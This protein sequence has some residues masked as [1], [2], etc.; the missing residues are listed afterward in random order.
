[1]P[2]RQP[3]MKVRNSPLCRNPI[4]LRLCTLQSHAG[5][6]PSNHAEHPK[7][8]IRLVVTSVV[9]YPDV[10]AGFRGEETRQEEFETRREHTHH[11]RTRMAGAEHLAAEYSGARAITPLPILVA[12]NRHCALRWRK[13][14]LGIG[15]GPAVSLREIAAEH[16][17]AAQHS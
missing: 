9:G 3:H 8:A 6:Q 14:G 4:D 10:R 1:M 5:F 2:G 12:Q 7:A 16:D 17:G 11:L 15:L 13:D